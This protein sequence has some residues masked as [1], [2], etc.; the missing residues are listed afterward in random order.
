MKNY[1]LTVYKSSAGSGKT[2]R[3][4]VEYIRLLIEKPD[5]YRNILAVTFTNKATE[6][7]KMRILSQLYG[8]AN[9]LP[10]SKDYFSEVKKG[11]E[12]SHGTPWADDS[13]RERAMTALSNL[14]SNYDQFRVMTIDSFFQVV[15]RNMAHE[16]QLTANLRVSLNEE[17]LKDLAV[18]RM[19]DNLQKNDQVFQ[20]I[21]DY[22]NENI[23]ESKN[24]N[25]IYGIKEFGNNIFKDH[26]KK[27]REKLQQL[28]EKGS[29][30]KTPLALVNEELRKIIATKKNGLMKYG[31][32]F[33][34]LLE[35]HDLGAEDLKG[36]SKGI[37]T[38]FRDLKKGKYDDDI[39]GKSSKVSDCMESAEAWV[40]TSARKAD[41]RS[42]A[43]SCLVSLINE[44]ENYRKKASY[45]IYTAELTRAHLYQLSLLTTID[46]EL[47][48]LNQET[49]SFF[50]SDTQHLLRAMIGQDDAPFVY[51]KIGAYLNHIMIDEF[52]DTSQVQ[53]NNFK[54][55][56]LDCM[57]KGGHNLIVGDVK[58]SIYRWRDGD[59]SLLNNIRTHFTERF[60]KDIEEMVHEDNQS[61]C[62]NRRSS[63]RVITFNNA[64]FK[65]AIQE[66]CSLLSEKGVLD[67][68]S[69]QISI[70]YKDVEQKIPSARPNEGYVRVSLFD[71]GKV[72]ED[73]RKQALDA[74]LKHISQLVSNGIPY[75]NI[76]ILI[77]ENKDI[78][79]IA[80][81]FLEHSDIPIVS[82][83]AFRLDASLSVNAIIIA[84]RY[85]NH[86]DDILNRAILSNIWQRR[87]RRET[88]PTSELFVEEGAQRLALPREL[89]ENRMELLS[90][91]LYEL[92]EKL[93]TLLELDQLEGQDPYIC[94][95]F[96]HLR[97]FQ[98]DN[99]ADIDGFLNFWDDELFK[100]TV[101]SVAVNGVRIV[102][103]H[104]SKG[105]EFE[106]VIIPFCE[107]DL[108]NNRTKIWCEPDQKERPYDQLPIVSVSYSKKV[109]NSMY[110]DDYY[111]ECLENTMDNLN[112]LYV[113]FTRAKKGLVVFGKTDAK[114][115]RSGMI[116]AVIENVTEEIRKK[117]SETGDQSPLV[118]K[119]DDDGF[120][121]IAYEGEKII[122]EYGTISSPQSKNE[123]KA[124]GKNTQNVF[125]QKESPLPLHLRSFP[126]ATSFT[127]SNESNRYLNEEEENTHNHYMQIGSVLHE[128][129]ARIITFDD[130]EIVLKELEMGGV[131]Y[132]DDVSVSDVKRLLELNMK[133]EYIKDWYSGR[134]EVLTE[135]TILNPTPSSN[136][137]HRPRP[138][139]V[140]IHDGKVVVVDFKFGKPKDEHHQQVKHYMELIGSM[141]YQDVEGYLWYVYNG[142]VL[143]LEA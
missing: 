134:W 131:L 137:S 71:K 142:L 82:D 26:Y 5:S 27:H 17:E 41:V 61:L 53:W 127:Q 55:L 124:E 90:K 89:E 15:L 84:L 35:D 103:I 29:N 44:A 62:W 93:F 122:F 16:L 11:L 95:F 73:F 97:E 43:N 128:V 129:F 72:K 80:K 114:S 139:R 37:F 13:I 125:L 45:D 22:M 106:H 133:D 113:A 51:E 60:G 48:L 34:Q 108:E 63:R 96:D 99:I 105:L 10:D 66:E 76:A 50:L 110:A 40:G 54:V 101:Q 112:L 104:R 28:T 98:S 1:P 79:A 36:K 49:N 31:N 87:I 140:M 47:Q 123:E 119:L 126:L 94:T 136:E 118:I 30:G 57:S 141:G 33:F 120:K 65:A 92:V 56:M 109:A 46:D 6:E 100:K 2:F 23:E 14:L 64:F 7:M 24:W 42:L 4:A 115:T 39:L 67:S 59:W 68:D 130:I 8:I 117:S 75:T 18:D 52:Q 86:P 91:P 9:G 58:Q 107:W 135:C 20:A 32:T 38:Y 138:D 121:D 143:K 21:L 116:E 70:A 78:S 12:E 74:M 132:N 25:V 88:T 19:I 3:L 85:L 83:L 111:K 102:S 81:Y 77:R 69:E